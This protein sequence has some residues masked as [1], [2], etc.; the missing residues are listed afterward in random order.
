MIIASSYEGRVLGINYTG[1]IVWDTALIASGDAKPLFTANNDLFCADLNNDGIEEVLA[2]NADGVLY[3][4]DARTGALLWDTKG[5]LQI[6]NVTPMYAVCVVKKQGIPYVACSNYDN[7]LYYLNA[8]G[9]FNKEVKSSTYSRLRVF[10]NFEK[11]FF[12]SNVHMANFLRPIPVDVDVDNDRLGM[13]ARNNHMQ[14]SG[15][16]YQFEP[17]ENLPIQI[18]GARTND[19]VEIVAKVPVGDMRVVKNPVDNKNLVIFGNSAQSINSGSFTLNPDID[20][21]TSAT[22]IGTETINGTL[23]DIRGVGYADAFGYRVP[24]TE[25]VDTASGQIYVTFFGSD[26]IIQDPTNLSNYRRIQSTYSYNDMWKDTVT[27]RVLLAGSQSGG[28]CVHVINTMDN[29]WEDAYVNLVPPGKI[30]TLLRNVA[31][32]KNSVSTFVKPSYETPETPNNVI[33]AT[34]LSNRTSI[35][36]ETL[37]L[38][39]KL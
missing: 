25:L 22:N 34:G 2:A 29:S 14:T 12:K 16:F 23:I 32:I 30:T 3:C 21:Y 20:N 33:F 27:D 15:L 7:S 4:L 11:T 1:A 9:T 36:I 10:G 18:N 37:L 31:A 19:G 28:S 26:A 6:N 8:N 39:W 38:I 5:I 17:L 35:P 24:Q 13:V